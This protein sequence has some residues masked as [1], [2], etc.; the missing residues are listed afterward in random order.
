MARPKKSAPAAGQ[1]SFTDALGLS[2]APCVPAIREAVRAWR[3]SKYPGATET[4]RELLKYWRS[5]DGH[6]LPTGKR[7]NYHPFQLEAIETLIYLWEVVKVRTRTQ[8]L[9]K[10]ASTGNLRL[11]EFDEFARYAVKMATGSG[12]T[13]VMSLAVAWQYLNAARD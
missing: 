5:P 3:A 13:K 10:Y 8:L 9:E 1:P 12:K 4:T 7:F 2:T 11:P 6:L